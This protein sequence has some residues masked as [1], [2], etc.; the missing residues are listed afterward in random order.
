MWTPPVENRGGGS[1]TIYS[2]RQCPDCD[3]VGAIATPEGQKV[4]DLIN[5]WRRSGH[6]R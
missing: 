1:R 6:L 4:L 2:P 3:G 5:R